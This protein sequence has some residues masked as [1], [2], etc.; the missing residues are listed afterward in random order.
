[1]TGKFPNNLKKVMDE[2]GIG[3]TRLADAVGST[4]QDI[5]RIA[6]GDR[7]FP[8]D[9]ADRIGKELGYSANYLLLIDEPENY[10][11]SSFGVDGGEA[12]LMPASSF[13]V[14]AATPAISPAGRGAA[15]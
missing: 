11:H 14:G 5:Y 4:K 2:K 8:P 3:P 1:M 13:E 6:R 7:K 10:G 15:S 12:G 9:L